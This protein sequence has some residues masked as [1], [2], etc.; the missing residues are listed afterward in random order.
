M[1]AADYYGNN[2]GGYAPPQNQ[3]SSPYPSQPQYAQQP[4][5]AG[6][7]PSQS[8][9]P[10][11]PTYAQSPQSQNYLAPYSQQSQYAR[12]GSA[13]SDAG[14]PP[15]SYAANDGT[16]QARPHSADPYST[17]QTPYDNNPNRAPG[18]EGEDG[19]RGLGATLIGG[20]AGGFLGHKLGKGKL[21]TMLG[22]AVGAVAANMIEHKFERKNS[23]QSHQSHQSHG[24][25]GSHGHGH[26]HHSH[27]GSH[28]GSPAPGG[29]YGGGYQGG[30][31]GGHHHGHHH[32]H[33]GHH[34]PGW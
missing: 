3:S 17:A 4:N 11:Q 6:G 33:H 8:P 15:P 14:Y 1:S 31:P 26:G 28:G 18:Q 23:N 9:Y 7:A 27:H 29:Y 20:G 19:E 5:Y 30:S 24:S 10:S 22:S 21:G 34:S 16:P 25:H 2:G 12:P 32:G 13:H